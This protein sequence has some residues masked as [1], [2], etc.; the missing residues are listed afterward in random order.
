MNTDLL[1]KNYTIIEVYHEL[2]QYTNP[3]FVSMQTI[4]NMK[5]STDGILWKIINDIQH[6]LAHILIS[7]NEKI[8][9]MIA[10][11]IYHIYN[12]MGID[13]NNEATIFEYIDIV[14]NKLYYPTDN[15]ISQKDICLQTNQIITITKDN[16]QQDFSNY[17]NNDATKVFITAVYLLISTR[18]Q[19]WKSNMER[20]YKSQISTK[21]LNL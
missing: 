4:Q 14:S 19:T 16:L 13:L 21:Y 8:L 5:Y 6:G 18:N 9:I 3:F 10:T 12:I 15:W 11:N 20:L 1:L 2:F 7:G 17:K